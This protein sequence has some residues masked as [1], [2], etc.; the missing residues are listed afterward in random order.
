MSEFVYMNGEYI[1][2]E[3]ATIPVMTHAFLYGTSI[4]E[5]I[6]AYYNEEENQLYAFRVPEHFER[7][8]KSARIMHMVPTNTIDE[9]CEITK[10]LL[11]KN[12][13]RQNTYA[14]PT[15]YKAAQR[16]GTSF[17]KNPDAFLIF[18]VPMEDYIDTQKG[19]K[20]CV[21]SW[22]RTSDNAIPP[23]AKVGGAYA[24]CALV[25]TDA[26]L[27]GFDDAITL[28][29]DGRV[30]EGSAMNLFLVMDGKLVTTL[31]TDNILQGITRD[32]I[33]KLA[34]DLDLEV[35][36]RV[37]DRTELYLADEAFFCGTGAQVSPI[38]SIDSRPLGDGNVGPIS[39]K[40]Q[41][42]YLDVVKGRVPQY[43]KWCMPIYD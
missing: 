24:N 22:R 43:K 1:E 33:I 5:G 9:Y 26:R 18:T 2:K 38:T 3:K 7:L 23:R 31:A 21:S 10:T 11:R 8:V 32:T 39:T 4:F 30:T 12:N 19:L 34:R 6:R 29:E 28:S 25:S 37:I 13:Y 27:A 42:L 36:T 17:L 40:L 35:E 20:I 41:N 14:R 16:V 15:H